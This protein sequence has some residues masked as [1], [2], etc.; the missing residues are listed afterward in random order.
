MYQED[1]PAEVRFS[2]RRAAKVTNYN[3]DDDS[4]FE[5]SDLGDNS[6]EG[7]TPPVEDV[8]GIDVI[9]DYRTKEGIRMYPQGILPVGDI[10]DSI[11]ADNEPVLERDKLEFLVRNPP[12]SM[13]RLH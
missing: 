2:T 7:L 11:V 6:Q 8:S 5:N 1:Q 9:L 3:E 12:I 13:L 10:T 4:A